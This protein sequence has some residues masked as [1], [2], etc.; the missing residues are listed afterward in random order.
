MSPEL[1]RAWTIFREQLAGVE[2]IRVPRWFGIVS[3]EKWQLY[4]FCDASE[5]AYA[6][7]I[8]LVHVAEEK[9][10]SR[11]ITA[12]SKVAPM[13]VISLPKLKLCGAVLLAR[14]VTYIL[15]KLDSQPSQIFCSSDSKVVLAWLH[16]PPSRW[17]TF[18]ANRVS[19]ILTSLPAAVWKHVLSADNPADLATRGETPESLRDSKLWWTG[20]SWLLKED[21]AWP[22]AAETELATDIEAKKAESCIVFSTVRHPSFVEWCLR[23]SSVDKIIQ[24]LAYIHRWRTNAKLAR[25]DRRKTLLKAA[26]LA[27]GRRALLKIVQHESFGQKIESLTLRNSVSNSSCL[28]RLLLFIDQEGILRVGGRLQN[29]FLSPAEKHPIILPNNHHVIGLLVLKAHIVSLH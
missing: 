1:R 11:L 8:Y 17:K 26:E 21:T 16:G 15:P 25:E 10:T 19:E 23:F 4:C 24:I 18:V 12:K 3:T 6:A 9:S 5:R 27:W 28:H 29:S 2:S 13:K 20:P 14:L 7:A 22:S